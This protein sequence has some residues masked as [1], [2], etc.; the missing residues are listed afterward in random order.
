MKTRLR[1]R[2][3]NKLPRALDGLGASKA[4]FRIDRSEIVK[5]LAMLSAGDAVCA[6]RS[7]MATRV[8]SPF[9]L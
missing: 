3:E 6:F 9:T 8:Y 1:T 4:E 2:L 5:D 7:G